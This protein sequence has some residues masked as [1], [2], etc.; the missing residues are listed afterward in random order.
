MCSACDEKYMAFLKT[1]SRRRV[2]R[3]AAVAIAAASVRPLA[4]AEAT[5]TP[6]AGEQLIL[7]KKIHSMDGSKSA[8]DAMLISGGRIV[9]VGERSKLLDRKMAGTV[10]RDFGDMTVLPGFIDPHMHSAFAI[11]R[12]WLDIGPFTTANMDEART[13]LKNAAAQLKSS[14]W[15]LGKM[16][17]PSLMPGKRLTRTDLDAI[18]TAVPIFVLENN[19]HVAY[20][21]SKAFTLAG[22]TAEMPDPPH[23]R[24][25]HDAGGQLSGRLEETSSFERFLAVLPPMS[26][27]TLAQY[28]RADF[29][30]ASA[31]GCTTLHDCGIGG[32]A[33]AK[34]LEMLDM[35]MAANPPVRY[36]GL[37]I[38]TEFAKWS[39]MGLKP[40][41]RGPR[42]SL[43]GIKAWVDGSNQA[44]TGYMREPYLNSKERGTANYT[45]A[46]IQAVIAQADAVGWQVGLHCNGDAGIDM[47]LDGFEA[48]LAGRSG[49]ERRHRIEH[50]SLL[51]PEQIARMKK[52]G[53]SPSFLIGHVHYWGHAFQADI[54]GPERAQLLD[55]CRSSLDAGMRITLHS[56]YNVTPI[57]PLRCM[58]NAVV[59]DMKYGGGIL[60]AAERITPYE[61]VR[62]MTIDAAWQCHLDKE[63]GSL[64]PSKSADFVVLEKDPMTIE[65][66]EIS[67]I[68]VHSTWLEGEQRFA[69]S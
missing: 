4:F 58:E 33:G 61:A 57:D 45:L 62:A 14:D 68:R 18:S 43:Y 41:L 26:D 38:S 32:L 19:G 65:P 20:A 63:C 27:Q 48:V 42:F 69:A 16:V 35:V 64:E 29:N 37:L 66:T 55:R 39:A 40:G 50:C 9:A 25:V 13:K 28:M 53:V 7:A 15:L 6:P 2:L 5:K 31:R 23:G 10:V 49:L 67:K 22:I 8:S 46:Q 17:D 51:H 24:Y 21:N 11:M 36:A 44:Q 30:D 3:D 59:R 60:N 47:G 56:D 54:L 12:P 1:Y 52:L 34:D